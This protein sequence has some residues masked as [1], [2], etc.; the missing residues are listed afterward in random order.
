[1]AIGLRTT[2]AY[3]ANSDINMKSKIEIEEISKK[4]AP[5]VAKIEKECFSTPFSEADIL[6]YI[7]NPIWN[8]FVATLD[9]SIIGYVSFT[10]IIDE[11]QIVNVA[12]SKSA[13]KMGV[14][15]LLIE[16]LLNF[17]RQNGVSK[18][19]LEVRKSNTPAIK[20]YEKFGFLA[21][22]VSKNHYSVPTEDAI[23]M[24]LTLG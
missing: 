4:D 3:R 1:M 8:F 7:D 24:N 23:L 6:G 15:T 18:L 16:R 21:V 11:C 17:C 20:L 9:G 13:R 19:F 2:T 10:K 5:C 12:V 22:G 14:G